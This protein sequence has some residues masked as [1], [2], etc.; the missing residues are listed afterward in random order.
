MC[1]YL[2]C[3]KR[4][5]KKKKPR[6]NSI[7]L[8]SDNHVGHELEFAFRIRTKQIVAVRGFENGCKNMWANGKDKHI[9][10][11]GHIKIKRHKKKITQM[12]YLSQRGQKT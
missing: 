3:C 1:V 10:T 4:G 6:V 12:L 11:C 2:R 7:F 9:D 8:S 5:E